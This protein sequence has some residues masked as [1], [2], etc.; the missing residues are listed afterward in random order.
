MD[1]KVFE[2]AGFGE[3]GDLGKRPAV[4]VVDVIYNTVGERP[5]PILESIKKY[6]LSCGERGW[7]AISC[8][9]ELL[10]AARAQSIPILYST[11][12]TRRDG[13]DLGRWAAKNR[14]AREDATKENSEFGYQ[15]VQEVAPEPQDV[16]IHKLKPSIF[17][18]TPLISILRTLD[19]DTLLVTGVTTSGCIRATVIDAFSYEFK[20]A[21]VEECVYD[22][23]EASHAMNL[24]DINAKYGDVIPLEEAKAYL[25]ELPGRRA[26]P[27]KAAR[28]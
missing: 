12:A 16:I 21:V 15:I 17:F 4:L 7:E 13:V 20:V 25:A 10:E 1:R 23:G 3:K 6:R 22:R 11:N 14:R 24:F 5:E 2:A 18:G 19:V 28:V 8:I 26:V 9:R 27:A